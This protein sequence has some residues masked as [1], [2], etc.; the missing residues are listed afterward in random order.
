MSP[1]IDI[2]IALVPC[3]LPY[4][5]FLSLGQLA[6]SA[7]TPLRQPIEGILDEGCKMILGTDLNRS[8]KACFTSA[9]LR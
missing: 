2:A 8:P 3:H 1:Q 7:T 4:R 6:K 9:C 5:K